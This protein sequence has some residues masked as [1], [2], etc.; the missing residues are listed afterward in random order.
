MLRWLAVCLLLAAGSFALVSVLT[1]NFPFTGPATAAGP[2]RPTK[3]NEDND[4]QTKAQN[5]NRN[6][7]VQPHGNGGVANDQPVTAEQI[8]LR[9]GGIRDE[10]VCLDARINPDSKQ[11]VPADRE[12]RLIF[13][14]TEVEDPTSVPPEKLYEFEM[15]FLATPCTRDEFDKLP[16]DQRVTFAGVDT[17]YRR[18]QPSDRLDPGKVLVARK[19]AY[20]RKLEVGMRV[21]RGQLLALVNPALAI[22]ELAVKVSKLEAAEADHKASIKTRDEAEKRYIAMK[23]AISAVSNAIAQDEV[24]GAKLTWDRYAEEARSKFAAISVAQREANGAYTTLKLHEIR[25]SIPGVVKVLYKS[26]G[27]AVKLNESILQLQNPD[28]LKAEGTVEVQDAQNL[29]RGMQV[30]VEPNVPQRPSAVLR[31][32]LSE[33]NCVAVSKGPQPLIA[34]GGEDAL[35]LIWGKGERGW[36]QR[37]RINHHSAIRALASSPAGASNLLLSGT[38]SGVG[39]IFNLA[40][41]KEEARVLEGRHNGAITCAAFSPDGELCATGGEDQC[42]RIWDSATGK[43]LH[44][45]RGAHRHTITSL[46]FAAP[47][48][49]GSTE[50]PL[51]LVSAGRDHQLIVWNLPKDGPPVRT[52][53]FDRRTG[54]VAQLGVSPD[55]TQVMFDQGKELRVLSLVDRHI[56]GTLQAQPGAPDFA[57]MALFSPSGDAILTNGAGSG[58]LQLWR[59]TGSN[60]RCAALRQLVWSSADVTCGAFAPTDSFAVTGTQDHQVLVWDMPSKSEIEQELTGTLTYVEQFIDTGA[61]VQ[62][63]TIQAELKRPAWLIPGGTATIVIPRQQNVANR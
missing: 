56:L 13:I 55:G 29:Q 14:G 12:G 19:K 22:D 31:G 63:V 42:I 28:Y 59:A 7:G 17:L 2:N 54:N 20:F 30:I 10:V 51:R 21:E 26:T 62:K 39:R 3:N 49:S 5:D 48:K 50:L 40:N 33:V 34:S 37:W 43:L 4:A 35:L 46:Q 52:S 32:H 60:K 47:V 58:R 57:T 8:G 24:R 44:E 36:E 6:A 27:D 18:W 38:A 45:K 53:D 41:L 61:S 16:R 25:A 9:A 23:K 1:G 11:E 15:A